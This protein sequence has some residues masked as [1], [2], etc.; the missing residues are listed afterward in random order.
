MH[1]REAHANLLIYGN[2]TRLSAGRP[3]EFILKYK[4]QE[5]LFFGRDPLTLYK[6]VH[7]PWKKIKCVSTENG[8]GAKVTGPD[9]WG[10]LKH[11]LLY[12]DTKLYLYIIY[13]FR[14]RSDEV[15]SYAKDKFLSNTGS[16]ITGQGGKVIS[17]FYFFFKVCIKTLLGQG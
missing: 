16:T 2:G 15:G 7:R 14:G 4:I 9:Q 8:G 12:A 1:L 10:N 17:F 11:K 5:A 6:L 3:Y 13:F